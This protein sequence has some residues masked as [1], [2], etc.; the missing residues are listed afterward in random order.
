[1]SISRRLASLLLLALLAVSACSAPSIPGFSAPSDPESEA[2]ANSVTAFVQTLERGAYDDAHALLCPE[3][4]TETDAAALR[5]E[6]EPHA[7]PWQLKIWATSRSD[8]S[9]NA[10]LALTPSGQGKREYTFAVVHA[11]DGWQVCDVST[12]SYQVDID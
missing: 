1:V 5:A 11:A 3:G 7:R 9:G 10:N 8:T 6:F 12:G 2:L 4:Q